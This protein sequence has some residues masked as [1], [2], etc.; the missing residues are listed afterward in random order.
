MSR[1]LVVLMLALSACSGDDA[2][3]EPLGPLGGSG[4]PTIASV[5]LDPAEPTA[6]GPVRAV[7]TW[8]APEDAE[9]SFAWS[10]DGAPV[11][12]EG[13]RLA[14]SWFA[15]GQVVS[16][17]VTLSA[18][19]Q[20]DRGTGE[21]T[22]V[23]A[24]PEA[25]EI[26]ISP[27]APGPSMALSCDIVT[28][29]TDADNDA[30]SY[31]TTWTVDG[32]LFEGDTVPAGTTR[33]GEDWVC[34]VV[35]SDVDGASV[36]ATVSAT[37]T[38]CPTVF[39]SGRLITNNA[40]L[41]TFVRI[42]D[43][44]GDGAPDA[45]FGG[46]QRL[47]WAPNEGDGYGAPLLIADGFSGVSDLAVFDADGDGDL[48]LAVTSR[49]DDTVAWLGNYGDGA[50][51]APRIVT[52]GEDGALGIHAADVDDDGRPDLLVASEFGDSVT[53]YRNQP[54]ENDGAAFGP[55]TVLAPAQNGAN[56]VTT[57]D[58]DGDGLLDVLVASITTDR[59]LDW[60]PNLGGSFGPPRPI[61]TWARSA[62]AMDAGDIDGDGD[63]D[64]VWSA[65]SDEALVWSENLGKGEW[66]PSVSLADDLFEPYG[67]A[68]GDLDGDG[69]PDVVVADRGAGIR[70][71]DNEGGG[72]FADG[73]DLVTVAR[74]LVADVCVPESLA[75][76]EMAAAA[77]RTADPGLREALGVL[78]DDGRRHGEL[79]WRCLRWLLARGGG[80]LRREVSLA[81]ERAL[82]AVESEPVVGGIGLVDYGILPPLLRYEVRQEGRHAVLA[83]VASDLLDPFEMAMAVDLI[84]S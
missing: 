64:L 20:T 77:S 58:V 83:E 81:L 46:D 63:A 7:V 44:N 60:L 67:V 27:P 5:E 82:D 76:L 69:D 48:D 62:R 24:T 79:G 57:V 17:E 59:P 75:A 51:T 72:R 73:V 70:W 13:R 61:A 66:A 15:K 39:E 35:A 65:S 45:V 84:A 31:E 36:P 3:D 26:A 38:A 40:D 33:D 16:V 42:A 1:P 47:Y 41:A 12:A 23:G 9:L 74:R 49:N 50:F 25:P 32:Q 4:P 22:V 21:A 71:F 68:V 2:A 6:A 56:K 37:I 19:G 8:T 54:H 30:I 11:E 18:D 34:T 55:P 80:A 78:A 53:L 29:A 28:P 14:P 43:I 10:V 52:T